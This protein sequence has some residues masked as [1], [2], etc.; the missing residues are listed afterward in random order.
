M[1]KALNGLLGVLMVVTVGLTAYAIAAGGSD[2]AI[3][4]NLIWGYCLMIGA[5]VAAVGG[6]IY[7]TLKS[8]AGAKMSILSVVLI[9]AIVGVAYFISAGHTVQIV[10][11]QNNG[12]FPHVDTV[13]TE[14][15]ILVTYVA[16]AASIVT[17]LVTEIWAAFK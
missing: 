6:A 7:S 12:Y 1:K 10:D 4:L 5:V 14:T 17:A 11:L 2:A 3:S 16:F 15:S 8:P 9:L 13:I